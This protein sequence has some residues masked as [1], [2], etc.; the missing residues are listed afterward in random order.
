MPFASL[1]ILL[2]G[3]NK[4]P[5][6]SPTALRDTNG[7]FKATAPVVPAA[8]NT[9]AL[10]QATTSMD[11]TALVITRPARTGS[12]EPNDGYAH[13]FKRLAPGEKLEGD[14]ATFE[15]MAFSVSGPGISPTPTNG[16]PIVPV[17]FF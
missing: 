13:V 10:D 16:I 17:D 3:C 7:Y 6:S 8:L 5:Y 4:P 11:G 14:G 15:F 9:S 12:S 1:A 2:C